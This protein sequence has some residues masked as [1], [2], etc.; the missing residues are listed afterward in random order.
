MFLVVSAVWFKK[1]QCHSI[2]WFIVPPLKSLL[3]YLNNYSCIAMKFCTV[4]TLQMNYNNSGNPLT[5]HLI[6]P[7]QSCNLSNTL[8]YN[9][10][11]AKLMTFPTDLDV[12]IG[13][14]YTKMLNMVKMIPATCQHVFV[15]IV[16]N[17]P[18][19]QLLSP[20]LF[21]TLFWLPL[22]T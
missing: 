14:S 21:I 16:F 20:P 2:G 11:P 12:L 7:G 1:R 5:F 19:R 22:G 3:K 15:V 6:S 10:K 8:L 17:Q 18:Q 4:I 9:Q 13:K